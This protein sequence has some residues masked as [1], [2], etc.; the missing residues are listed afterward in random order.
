MSA[1]REV[2]IERKA[3]TIRVGAASLE[4]ELVLPASATAVVLHAGLRDDARA[5]ADRLA[6]EARFASLLVDLRVPADDGQPADLAL[7]AQRLAVVTDWITM[8]EAL[9]WIPFGYSA[10]GIAAAAALVTA[11]ARREVRAVVCRSGRPDLAGAALENVR[12]PTLLVVDEADDALVALNRSARPR[13]RTSEL[14]VVPRGAIEARSA[15]W[16]VHALA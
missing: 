16:L 3:V 7:L 14:A 13:L 15:D 9:R 5:L 8:H 6:R 12:V 4:A 10:T 11:S 1:A 2:S